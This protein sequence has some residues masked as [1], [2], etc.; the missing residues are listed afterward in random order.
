MQRRLRLRRAEDFQY[1]RQVGRSYHSRLLHI[2]LAS[3]GL[4]ANRYGVITSKRLGNAVMRNRVRR[5][6]REVLRSLDPHLE[7][8]FDIVVV[9]RPA[10]VAQPFEQVQRNVS[11]LLRQA[12]LLRV[13]GDV[14]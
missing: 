2:N 9:A 13:E 6:L 12:G 5:R 3:N 1:V 4:G 10:I 14:L 8:G 11:R 7:S